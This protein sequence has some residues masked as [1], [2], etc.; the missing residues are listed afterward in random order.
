MTFMGITTT[1]F[2]MNLILPDFHGFKAAGMATQSPAT[3][4]RVAVAVEEVVVEDANPA[5]T[6]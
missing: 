2:H 6:S 3:P 4:S 5:Q 1:R